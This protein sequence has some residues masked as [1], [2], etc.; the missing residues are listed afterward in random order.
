MNVTVTP[1]AL[2]GK[3]NIP[4]SK[5]EGHRLLMAAAF[6]DGESRLFGMAHSE[7]IDA[8]I[9][10]MR[11]MGAVITEDGSALTVKGIA[12]KENCL[13]NSA[14]S[15][16]CCE[17]GSTM[18]FI[19]PASAVLSSGGRFKGRGR[20]PKRPQKPYED[21][22]ESFGGKLLSDSDGVTVSGHLASGSYKLRG[23]ISSQFFTGLM[24]ALPLLSGN[25]ELIS[26]TALESSAYIDMTVSAMRRAGVAVDSIGQGHWLIRGSQSYKPF[27]KTVEGDWSQ[28][29]FWLAAKFIGADIEIVGCDEASLQGDKAIADMLCKMRGDKEVIIDL[30]ECPDLLPPAAA[31]AALRQ[32]GSVT[33]FVGA[34]RLRIK[35]SDRIESV[36]A[37]LTSMGAK[38]NEGEDFLTVYGAEKLKGGCV[39]DSHN[40]HRIAMMS[41]IAALG[42]LEPVTITGAECVKKSYPDFWQVYKSL[43]GIIDMKGE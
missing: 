25:S 22:F 11:E 27:E 20:L 14:L 4:P 41:A 13:K 35:E 17:S 26:T 7:D 2:F 10:C 33:R 40:D 5:S 8:T 21:I 28:A 16:D 3:V 6:A 42:C 38:T 39:I 18:R 15:F 9:G 43:G 24:Y 31:A 32:K 30:S 34:K 29:A 1:S 36:N 19:I 12:A 37:A 23:D